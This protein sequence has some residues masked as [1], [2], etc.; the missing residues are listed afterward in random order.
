M[1][2]K[3]RCVLCI[4]GLLLAGC[5]VPNPGYSP[6]DGA[7][8]DSSADVG[9]TDTGPREGGPGGDLRPW[10]DSVPWQC[11]SN[12]DCA[13]NVSCTVDSCSAKKTCEHTIKA[14]SCLIGGACYVN[15]TANPKESCQA[16]MVNQS[17]TSWTARATGTPCAAD[18]LS[19]TND[20]CSNGQ[21]THPVEDG[22]CLIDSHCYWAGDK[23]PANACE[24]C[25]PSASPGKWTSTVAT[26]CYKDEDGDGVGVSNIS[27]TAC[28]CA[29]GWAS[30][31]GD[32][33]DDNA[34]VFP[35]QTAYFTKPY[36]SP[37][38]DSWDY[39][40]NF[41]PEPK[42][43]S[44]GYCYK[45]GSSCKWQAGWAINT[46]LEPPLCGVTKNWITACTMTSGYC[47]PT[48]APYTQA[49]R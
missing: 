37:L 40:C 5:T 1:A 8:L 27:Q 38:G 10:P 24:S 30:K 19:C 21:C 26:I 41:V 35:G 45:S 43:A 15:W 6:A 42:Y 11:H 48:V 16:C 29:A 32:C 22:A 34:D 47:T 13:D 17:N 12:P 7:A 23:N 3:T 28:T 4:G 14:D 2:S 44:V 18:A 36:T 31:N 49:C 46:G 9:Q 20:V 39:N 25:D 33:D